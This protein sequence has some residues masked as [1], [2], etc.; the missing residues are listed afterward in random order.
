[1]VITYLVAQQQV[2]ATIDATVLREGQELKLKL[3]LGVPPR[4]V[5][6]H[7]AGQPPSYLVIAGLVLTPLTVPFL[8]QVCP[9]LALRLRSAS[10]SASHCCSL[11]GGRAAYSHAVT[12]GWLCSASPR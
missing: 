2:G 8:E 3:K 1:M 10:H 7:V 12:D 4:L 6:T 5:P 9:W 11:R